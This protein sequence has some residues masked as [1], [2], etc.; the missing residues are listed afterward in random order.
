[1]PHRRQLTAAFVDRVALPANGERWVADTKVRG[2]GLRIWK[3]TRGE[4][5]AYAIRTVSPAG[6]KVRRTYSSSAWGEYFFPRRGGSRLGNV[7]QHARSWARDEIDRISGRRTLDDENKLQRTAAKKAISNLTLDRLVKSR[8]RG[9]ALRG[10]KQHYIDSVTKL[11]ETVVPQNVKTKKALRVTA[12]DIAAFLRKLDSRPGAARAL[13][14][15]VGQ[16]FEAAGEYDHRFY[17][18]LRDA[19]TLYRPEYEWRRIQGYRK[20]ASENVLFRLFKTLESESECRVQAAF[21]RL[22]FEFDAPA[23]RLMRA[24]WSHIVKNRW[25]PW[26]PGERKYWNVHGRFI[27]ERTKRLLEKLRAENQIEF[28]DSPFLFPSISS[29]SGHIRTY[30]ALWRKTAAAHKLDP[31]SLRELVRAFHG[32]IKLREAMNRLPTF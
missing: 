21:I 4:G 7:L 16:V 23:D 2:F 11:Y 15:F 29:A 26:V 3:C 9:M 12:R 20:G 25:F 13:R 17:K 18:V 28:G 19:R 6:K 1:M 5:K 30:D 8:L 22:L 10:L 32:T 14:G 24:E 27:D 31:E